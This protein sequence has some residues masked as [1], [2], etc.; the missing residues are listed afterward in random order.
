MSIPLICYPRCPL[1]TWQVSKQDPRMMAPFRMVVA[2]IRDGSDSASLP[3]QNVK[4][5]ARVDHVVE[6]ERIVLAV[7]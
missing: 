1:G 3:P 7:H 5:K 2:I 4:V 6:Y